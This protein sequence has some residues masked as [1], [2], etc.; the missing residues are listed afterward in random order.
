MPS[1]DSVVA[2]CLVLAVSA[3]SGQSGAPGQG[4]SSSP[5]ALWRRAHD[6]AFRR[7][8]L[9]VVAITGPDWGGRLL[10][11]HEADLPALVDRLDEIRSA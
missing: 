6:E 8:R 10:V 9:P 11:I 7:D 5:D 4:Q 1:R 3:V 2:L